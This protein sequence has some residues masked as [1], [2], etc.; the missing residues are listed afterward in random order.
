M[1]TKGMATG[2]AT[3]KRFIQKNWVQTG[4]K[5]ILFNTLYVTHYYFLCTT[6]QLK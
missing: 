1:R 6:L 3:L 5:S 2:E 4:Y